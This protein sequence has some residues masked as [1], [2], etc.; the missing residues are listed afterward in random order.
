MSPL[1]ALILSYLFVF[2]II[3]I[4]TIVQKLR[5]L[6]AEFSR[7]FVH[8]GVGNWV[9]VALYL[10]T[11]WRW[12]L[13]PPVSF[14]LINYLSYRY[15]IFKAMELE[16]KNPGTIYYAISL[17]ILTFLAFQ[18]FPVQILFYL[19]IVVMTWGDGMAA[20]IGKKW[21]VKVMRQGRS[22]GGAMAFFLFSSIASFIFL[23]LYSDFSVTGRVFIGLG[24]SMFGALVEM[25]SPKNWDNITVPL[26]TALLT[27][28][29]I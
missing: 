8:I 2:S 22:I 13:I 23:S 10:F 29:F 21:P 7:K 25:F 4:A 28:I 14:V 17:T 5:G 19:G 26:A 15:S 6:S 9:F 27:G 18:N 3:F 20:V 1:V 11:D 12:A 16:E 24:I